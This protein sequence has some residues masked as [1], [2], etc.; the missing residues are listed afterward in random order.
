[1]RFGL[2]VASALLL[3]PEGAQ[4][5]SVCFSGTDETR[6]AFIQTTIFM[7]AAPLVMIGSLAYWIYRRAVV[8]S[9]PPQSEA[10]R[11]LLLSTRHP[12]A[13]P[14]VGASPSG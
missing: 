13:V 3:T 2:V 5:C 8:L 11:E 7:T 14:R 10:V 4:A 6:M 1:M 9:R 12:R